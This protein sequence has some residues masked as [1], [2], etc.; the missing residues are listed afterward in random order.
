MYTSDKFDEI[1][2]DNFLILMLMTILNT[3][4]H[5]TLSLNIG[6]KENGRLLIVSYR[7]GHFISGKWLMF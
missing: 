2:K 5:N 7:V 3:H 4:S 1:N 6:E